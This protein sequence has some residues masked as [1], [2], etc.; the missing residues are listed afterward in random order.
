ML[1]LRQPGQPDVTGLAAISQTRRLLSGGAIV[2][3]KGL[4]GYHLACDAADQTAVSVPRKRKDRGDKPFA[5]MVADSESAAE[6]ALLSDAERRLLTDSRR[7]VV[8][9]PRRADGTV[10]L[11]A[12]VAPDSPDLGIMLPYTPVHRLLFG[13]AG[14]PPGPR[15][16]VMTS[17]NLAGEPIVTDDGEA[18][19]RLAPLADA[20]LCHDRRIHV[21]CDDS[22]LRIVDHDQLP[23]RR[24]RGNAPLPVALPIQIRPALAVGSDLKNMLEAMRAHPLGQRRGDHRRVR[25]RSCGHRGDYDDIRRYQSGGPA[26][27]RAAAAHLLT[28]CWNFELLSPTYQKTSLPGAGA[29]PVAK[30]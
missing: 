11:A 23:V 4:G 29:P 24:S 1:T 26:A 30:S 28:A 25:S 2:A 20:W 10:K 6:L 27:R 17:G 22:V 16:L 13:L 19:S 14:D 3:V 8:L 15:V 5:I 7:P 12:D 21:P 18:A 9:L